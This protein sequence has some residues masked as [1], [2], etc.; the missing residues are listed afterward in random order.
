MRKLFDGERRFLSAV[1]IVDLRIKILAVK[2][3]MKKNT[4]CE[5]NDVTEC[6]NFVSGDY[7]S[8]R[9]PANCLAALVTDLASVR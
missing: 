2:R 5:S 4:M 6:S 8:K 1:I 7:L 9:C 3:S